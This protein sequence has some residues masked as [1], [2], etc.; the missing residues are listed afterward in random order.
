M[1]QSLR[2]RV[3]TLDYVEIALS[4]GESL[5][6]FAVQD[7]TGGPHEFRGIA[8]SD[9]IHNLASA[10]GD[11]VLYNIS[12]TNISEEIIPTPTT[13]DTDSPVASSS[14]TPSSSTSS[15]SS[16]TA[17]SPLRRPVLHLR[18]TDPTT[19]TSQD[20][21]YAVRAVV[22]ADG[23]NSAVSRYL[24]LG[25]LHFVGQA[26]HRGL[27]RFPN[28][29][30]MRDVVTDNTVRMI[31]GSGV[32]AG[33]YPVD[34]TQVGRVFAHTQISTP[35]SLHPDLYTQISTPPPPPTSYNS[36]PIP[37]DPLTL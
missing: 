37:S 12:V 6:R 9:L 28:R 4:S 13:R 27:A 7:A 1:G 36:D 5:R 3:T 18:Y 8:R 30:A 24:G 19:G 29:A 22:G 25:G 33:I 32:R 23:V 11:S 17:T 15:S 26:A 20:M 21:S 14:S 35:R 31:W 34:D 16:G 10:A 2:S